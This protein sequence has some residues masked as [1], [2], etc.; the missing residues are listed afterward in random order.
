MNISALNVSVVE[1]VVLFASLY[2]F[3]LYDH[4]TNSVIHVIL[5][6]FKSDVELAQ[7]SFLMFSFKCCLDMYNIPELK[8]VFP[9]GLEAAPW[10]VQIFEGK[11]Q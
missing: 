1:N 5:L 8:H 11:P 6:L 9:P 4:I 10:R 2:C 3:H 7:S